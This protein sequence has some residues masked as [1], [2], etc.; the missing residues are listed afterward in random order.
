MKRKRAIDDAEDVQRSPKVP[1]FTHESDI[2][3][4]PKRRPPAE[5][6]LDEEDGASDAQSD[7]DDE[8]GDEE[9][10]KGPLAPKPKAQPHL[11]RELPSAKELKTIFEA[12]ELF[13]SNAFKLQ[14]APLFI[15]FWTCLTEALSICRSTNSSRPS[16]QSPKNLPVRHL[17]LSSLSYMTTF[18]TFHPSLPHNLFKPRRN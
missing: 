4:R 13:K 7:S 5:N 1:R 12:S 11:H 6:L 10:S 16:P 15:G 3:D 18:R 8:T 17:K 9:T 14:V 2:S